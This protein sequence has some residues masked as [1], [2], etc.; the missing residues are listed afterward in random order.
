LSRLIIVGA[1]VGLLYAARSFIP[2]GVASPRVG[3]TTLAFGFVLLVSFFA[4]RFVERLSIPK[5]TGY[6]VIGIVVGPFALGLVTTTMV[7]ALRLIDG[8]AICL[9]ALTAGGEL[10]FRRM[11][12]LLA[13]IRSMMLWG[14]LGTAVGL[15]LLIYAIR[16][17]VPFLAEL[18]PAAAAA[19]SA[20]LGITLASQSP[21]V[22]QALLNETHSDGPLS[23]TML[24]VVVI[25]DLVVIVLYAI[26]SSVANTFLG[27][28]ADPLAVTLLVGWELFGSV[29]I[30]V[31]VGAV[32]SLYLRRVGRG[33]AL[34]VL[35][36]C[37]VT[38][39]VG[40]RAH[41]DP[42]I[43]TLT[44][45]VFLENMTEAEADV[46]IHDIEGASL[47]IY[48]IFFAVAGAALDLHIVATVAIP[49]GILAVG[50]AVMLWAGCTIGG[51]RTRAAP[52]VTRYAW[53]GLLPQAG[54]ALALALLFERSMPSVGVEAGALVLG[55]VGINQVI[56]PIFMRLGLIRSGEAG[57][58]LTPEFGEE[59][60]G[61]GE[62]TEP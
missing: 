14:V 43:I 39:Q 54:L 19:V 35:L 55:V 32:L 25:A 10:S 11:K 59:L 40:R 36:V 29:F 41:L 7:Q 44:A 24:G 34:F 62:A 13:T 58:K 9:I 57:K 52:E 42:L 3:T 45:G 23:K 37:I 38:E 60:A 53:L 8:V 22:V 1:I 21:A 56:T 61:P 2:D 46:L 30:G 51:K 26:A 15:S 20:V 6:L 5:V 27:G 16:P 17:L 12:P 50:R 28:E 4:G 18:D 31:A 33:A 47:P 49:A 48:V